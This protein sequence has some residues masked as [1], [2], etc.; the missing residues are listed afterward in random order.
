MKPMLL[1]IEGPTACGKSSLVRL[2]RVALPRLKLFHLPRPPKTIIHSPFQMETHYDIPRRRGGDILLDRW[3][4]SN[5][6]YS[7][8]FGNQARCAPWNLETWAKDSHDPLV[9]FLRAGA[10]T[11]FN[12]IRERGESRLPEG[13][14]KLSNLTRLVAEY[15]DI[16][17]NCGLPKV[18]VRTDEEGHTP[19]HSLRAVL[20]TLESR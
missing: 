14:D 4:Y 8:V 7:A 11:L 13:I 17:A 10:T 3:V 6:A 20:Q 5:M 2:L 9:V 12:R 15:E 1:V 16:E 18:G 19:E